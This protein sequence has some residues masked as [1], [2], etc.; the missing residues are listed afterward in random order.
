[1]WYFIWIL[2]LFLAASFTI[3]HVVRVEKSDSEI[4]S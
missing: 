4:E 3:W 1:M 2:G